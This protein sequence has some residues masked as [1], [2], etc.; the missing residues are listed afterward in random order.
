MRAAGTVGARAKTLSNRMKRNVSSR[1]LARI[2]RELLSDVSTVPTDLQGV[3]LDALPQQNL[4]CP[5]LTMQG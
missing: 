4:G 3:L 1:G 2:G 5:E